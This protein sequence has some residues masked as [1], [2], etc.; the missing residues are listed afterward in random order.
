[1]AR[2]LAILA[3]NIVL[4]GSGVAMILSYADARDQASQAPPN[5]APAQPTP[6]RNTSEKPAAVMLEGPDGEEGKAGQNDNAGTAGQERAR[7]SRPISPMARPVERATTRP[8]TRTRKPAVAQPSGD[9]PTVATPEENVQAVTRRVSLLVN[10][11]Q[12]QLQRCYQR[13]SRAALPDEPLHGR[14]DVHITLAPTDRPDDR[15][16]GVRITKNETGSEQ[17]ADC[18]TSLF[19][20]WTFPEPPGEEPLDLVWPLRFRARK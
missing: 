2:V 16:A 19:S 17:L 6:S 13:A 15:K 18:V 9:T 10:R 7:G 5:P 12:K 11:H 8:R 1:M 14:I 20:S 4:A 3:V